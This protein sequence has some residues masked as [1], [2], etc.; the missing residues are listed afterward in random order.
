MF[1]ILP[2][3]IALADAVIG[4]AA[5]AAAALK[6]AVSDVAEYG[7]EHAFRRANGAV[8]RLGDAGAVE[9]LPRSTLKPPFG[10]ALTLPAA[11]AYQDDGGGVIVDPFTDRPIHHEHVPRCEPE[12]WSQFI[13]DTRTTLSKRRRATTFRRARP[14]NTDSDRGRRPIDRVDVRTR[15]FIDGHTPEGTRNEAAFA[16]GANLLGCGVDRR[17]AERLILAGAAMCGLPQRE[18]MNA[19]KSAVQALSRRGMPR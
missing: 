8:A 2:E 16:A 3:P 13:A 14:L 17:E 10:W 11:G 9:L 7:A 6:V 4:V 5:L 12:S 19:F 15:A 1:L 18:A